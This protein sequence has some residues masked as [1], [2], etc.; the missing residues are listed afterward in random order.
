MLLFTFPLPLSLL[1]SAL[2]HAG[3]QKQR[4]AIARLLYKKDEKDIF[5]FDDPLSAVDVHVASALWSN[6]LGNQSELQGKTR[7]VVMNSHYHFLQQA[8]LVIYC[9]TGKP[10]TLYD[11]PKE[12][13]DNH[14]WLSGSSGSNSG[15]SS[16]GGESGATTLSSRE[17]RV[18]SDVGSELS[19]SVR[20]RSVSATSSRGSGGEE[21]QQEG[22]GEGDD[23]DDDDDTKLY[24]KENRVKGAVTL[25]TYVVWF[26][27]AASCGGGL[28]LALTVFLF[29]STVQ[30]KKNKYF[31]FSFLL[32]LPS[33]PITKKNSHK[34][35]LFSSSY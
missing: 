25:K 10:I 35:S 22:E 29:F 6:V 30:G 20:Q 14:P 23:D 1:S 26:H 3:G 11:T 21:Q 27:S 19:S 33:I 31:F 5:L 17:I 28:P 9:E 32:P 34:N 15:S 16:G 12:A 13:M 4:V 7:L 24:Q 18:T 8:D 2:F